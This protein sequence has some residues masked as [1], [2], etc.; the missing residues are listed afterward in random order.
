MLHEL[1]FQIGAAIQSRTEIG[2]LRNIRNS[3]YTIAA[4]LVRLTEFESVIFPVGT[5]CCVR[6]SYKR[7]LNTESVAA[8]LFYANIHLCHNPNV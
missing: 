1:V 7:K 3:H 6:L 5:G 2:C 4:K 8:I